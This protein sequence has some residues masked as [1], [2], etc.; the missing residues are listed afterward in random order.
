M[1]RMVGQRSVR[2]T[3]GGVVSCMQSVGGWPIVEIQP[4]ASA[5]RNSKPAGCC[6]MSGGGSQA[7]TA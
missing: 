6:V 2:R 4:H 5:D 1:A 3:T 7:Y